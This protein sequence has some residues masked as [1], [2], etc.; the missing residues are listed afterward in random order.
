MFLEDE[1]YAVSEASDG[2]AALEVGRTNTKPLIMLLDFMMPK[3]DGMGV[4]RVAATD[5]LL[6]RH[7]YIIMT[8][9]HRAES[10]ELHQLHNHLHISSVTKPFDLDRLSAAITAMTDRL[11][12]QAD[13]PAEME[14]PESF[15]SEH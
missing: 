7:G 9:L 15:T 13:A 2:I 8:A 10:D 1:A 6:A 4:L 5:P 12:A 14:A 11:R 3:L